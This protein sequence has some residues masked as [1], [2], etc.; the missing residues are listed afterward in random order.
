MPDK[1]TEGVKKIKEPPSIMPS[2]PIATLPKFDTSLVKH[3][4]ASVSSPSIAV[5]PSCQFIFSKPITVCRDS[6]D[7]SPIPPSKQFSRPLDPDSKI[8]EN[9]EKVTINCVNSASKKELEEMTYDPPSATKLKRKVAVNT[10]SKP[11]DSSC[12]DLKTGSVLDILNKYVVPVAPDIKS[13][14][15]ADVLKKSQETVKKS[16][17]GPKWECQGCYVTNEESKTKCVAC[18][19]PKKPIE[20]KSKA[21]G[22]GD[23]F[24]MTSNEWECSSCL[25]R[26]NIKESACVACG[27]SNAEAKTVNSVSNPHRPTNQSFAGFGDKFKRPVGSWECTVC[28]VQNKAADTKCVSCSSAKPGAAPSKP[29]QTS[30]SPL[31][32]LFKK[33][34]GSWECDTCLV[35]NSGDVI[36][37]VSCGTTKPGAKPSKPAQTFSFGIP[38]TS[39]GSPKFS[40]GVSSTSLMD[41]AAKPTFTSSSASSQ[42]VKPVFTFGIPISQSDN[43]SASPS[44]F[45]GVKSISGI[46]NESNSESTETGGEKNVSHPPKSRSNEMKLDSES[47]QTFVPVPAVKKDTGTAA[48]E[49]SSKSIFGNVTTSSPSTLVTTTSVSSS[50]VSPSSLPIFVN[51]ISSTK[52]PVASTEKIT[53]PASTPVFTFGA[54]ASSSLSQVESTPAISEA[55]KPPDSS[56]PIFSSVDNRPMATSPVNKVNIFSLNNSENNTS[57]VKPN[58]FTFGSSGTSDKKTF[59]NSKDGAFIANPVNS[60][61]SQ[62]SCAPVKPVFSFTG[63]FSS[64]STTNQLKTDNGADSF[65]SQQLQQK[66]SAGA[67]T[68]KHKEPV[69]VRFQAKSEPVS[70]P[71]Q[72]SNET[73]TTNHTNNLSNPTTGTNQFNSNFTNIANSPFSTQGSIFG[74]PAPQP[75]P[76]ASFLFGASQANDRPPPAPSF[77]FAAQVIYVFI[78]CIKNKITYV[79]LTFP[80]N[81]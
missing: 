50:S 57:E 6:D 77:S 68:L 75:A 19:Q 59:L 78:N 16:A 8:N 76:T 64:G 29:I 18:D 48:L 20:D 33:P 45:S 56:I 10:E 14:S 69:P 28:L 63:G 41:A 17:A 46:D 25:V 73:A 1:K 62:S 23:K 55:A 81:M 70:N 42:P 12:S 11:A 66:I 51:Q 30:A 27:Q 13:G 5:K 35:R 80:I 26:N 61:G 22:F 72:F 49:T 71:F 44:I 53:P 24:K 54:A 3:T 40:F 21:K 65:G 9:K 32:N 43:K 52:C 79:L 2:L 58:M 15:I 36:S 34:E 7:V 4:Q 37:C 74:S 67:K 60:F 47:V 39:D 38:P 31:S